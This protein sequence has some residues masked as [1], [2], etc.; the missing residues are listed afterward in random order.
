MVAKV[1]LKKVMK[2]K[3]ETAESTEPKKRGR[4]PGVSSGPRR[5][6]TVQLENGRFRNLNP[7]CTENGLKIATVLLR[8]KKKLIAQGATD[9]D[10]VVLKWNDPIL[11]TE[12]QPPS[13]KVIVITNRQVKRIR[14][15]DAILSDFDI[16]ISK[17]G[18][19]YEAD[20]DWTA[21]GDEVEG[22]DSAENDEIVDG[23]CEAAEDQEDTDSDTELEDDGLVS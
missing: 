4:K 5:A 16:L 21:F 13:L 8:V 9:A 2:A 17:H 18:Y 1:K 14:Y 15:S 23:E 10:A 19:K 3:P 20:A 22:E 11:T 7:Y 12:R 6:I